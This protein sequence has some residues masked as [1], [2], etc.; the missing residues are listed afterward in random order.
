MMSPSEFLDLIG[1]RYDVC[2]IVVGE[3]F[4]FGR[5]RAGDAQFLASECPAR[6]WSIDV[7]PM[8]RTRS[9][10]PICST[11][12]RSLVE[13]GRL[14]AAW[15]MLG[16]PYFCTGAVTHGDGRG[17]RLGLP[18]ANIGMDRGR[19]EPRRGVYATVVYADGMWY[20]GAA[21]IG[22][23][24]TF[25]GVEGCRLEVNL[26][27][28]EGD[29]YGRTVSVFLLS[30]IRDEIRF[31]SALELREQI[32]ADKAVISKIAGDAL[33]ATPEFWERMALSLRPSS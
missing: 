7:L 30:H 10:V 33:G 11:A 24:P 6:G 32:D 19:V 9:G 2:G 16:Y 3:G 26:M 28:Y 22:I 29:L 20:V 12:V 5:D 1:S 8:E 17:R 18:T 4:R 21:N 27:N 25:E 31:G 15:E 14:E 13:E 23:N